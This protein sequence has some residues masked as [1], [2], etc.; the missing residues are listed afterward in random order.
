M[1][2]WPSRRACAKQSRTFFDDGQ[3]LRRGAVRPAGF[4]GILTYSGHVEIVAHGL[5]Q[6]AQLRGRNRRRRTA[7]DVD[8]LQPQPVAPR[9]RADLRKFAAQRLDIRLNE[10]ARFRSGAGNK[11]AIAASGRTERNGDV[12]AVAARRVQRQYGRLIVRRPH[13]QLIFFAVCK[14]FIPKERLYLFLRLT[15]AAHV[16][17]QPHR[18]HTR[19]HAPGRAAARGLAQQQKQQAAY[20]IFRLLRRRVLRQRRSAHGAQAVHAHAAYKTFFAPQHRNGVRPAGGPPFRQQR[21]LKK[22]PRHMLG[23][24]AG[25]KAPD[26]DLHMINSY[27]FVKIADTDCSPVPGPWWKTPRGRA[28]PARFPSLRRTAFSGFPA[29][30]PNCRRAGPYG[31]RPP[32]TAC[33]R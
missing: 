6:R 4:H 24:V 7:A 18:P 19:Q 15:G 28:G 3:L 21:G 22:Q 17:N 16:V 33:R 2:P 8:G 26:I 9:Q 5:H 25:G 11:A 31:P 10:A 12:Q 20:L 29:V 23:L 32:R 13:R 30:C 1:F 27:L 14:V